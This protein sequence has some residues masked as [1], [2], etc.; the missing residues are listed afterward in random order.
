MSSSATPLVRDVADSSGEEED[1]APK[2]LP[3]GQGLGQPPQPGK[4]PRTRFW[5][6]QS[7]PRTRARG[8]ADDEDDNRDGQENN[9]SNDE[10]E[11]MAVTSSGEK[12]YGP[13]GH[14]PTTY[15]ELFRSSVGHTT[16]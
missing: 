2:R 13:I 14:G 1:A 5:G 12:S 15:A 4:R 10:R 3:Q 11:A 16:W 6:T 9:D 8:S 7:V